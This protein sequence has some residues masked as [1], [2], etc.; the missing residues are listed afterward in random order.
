MNYIKKY[1]NYLKKNKDINCEKI[2]YIFNWVLKELNKK[3]VNFIL[4]IKKQIMLSNLLKLFAS[5]L[6]R[7]EEEQILN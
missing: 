2:R 1:N 3:I 6:N 4:I 7:N 5:I